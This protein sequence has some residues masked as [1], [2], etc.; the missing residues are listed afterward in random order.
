M[1][2]RGRAKLNEKKNT[3]QMDRKFL[4]TNKQDVFGLRNM[5]CGLGHPQSP[6]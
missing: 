2:A 6:G 4:K 5:V 3:I 1:H